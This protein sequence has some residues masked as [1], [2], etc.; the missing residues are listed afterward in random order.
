MHQ[1]LLNGAP[2]YTASAMGPSVDGGKILVGGNEYGS[3]SQPPPKVRRLPPSG[4]LSFGGDF[5][6]YAMDGG[7]GGGGS[8]SHS[9]PVGTLG[10]SLS[11]PTMP[12]PDRHLFHY[13]SSRGSQRGTAISGAA[14][15]AGSF[16]GGVPY[17]TAMLQALF[18]LVYAVFIWL[19]LGTVAENNDAPWY[20]HLSYRV[21]LHGAAYL[22]IGAVGLYVFQQHKRSQS[23]G[24]LR[25]YR[26]INTLR[27][28]PIF[29][30]SIVNT[31]L[32][33]LWSLTSTSVVSVAMADAVLRFTIIAEV[34]I[35]LPCFVIYAHRVR[36]HN[37][38][39]L[40]PT[41]SR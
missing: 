18:I 25:F 5:N 34:M 22:G 28:L 12:S 36:Q 9:T 3:E 21:V 16:K 29:A 32:F 4:A 10:G 14:N 11:P 2:R 35:V 33:P 20:L 24:Y 40:F 6:S 19:P 15:A 13:T 17:A 39:S 37:R 30:M 8:A 23:R 26:S 27:R 41:R 1:R 7:G 38:S 31:L